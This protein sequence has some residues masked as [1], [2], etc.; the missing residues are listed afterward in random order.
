MTQYFWQTFPASE[1]EKLTAIG[2]DWWYLTDLTRYPNLRVNLNGERFGNETTATLY[3]VHGA[4]LHMQPQETEFII[5]DQS[6]I[7]VVKKKG[8]AGIEEQFGAF[9]GKHEFFMEFNEPNDTKELNEYENTPV[10]LGPILDCFVGE[11]ETVYKAD[12]IEGL[13]RAMGVDE[14]AFRA[15]VD[16]YNGAVE[17][18]RDDLFFA[19]TKRL[20]PVKKGPFYAVRSTARNLGTLGGMYGKAYVD[21]E[22]GTLGF[23]YTSGRLAGEAVAGY[24]KAK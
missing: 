15:S 13:A 19:D 18:G 4:E 3:S 23:A 10:D 1:M 6:M 11:T 14:K 22:G 16:Q 21:F 17:S 7:D 5:L 2:D 12:T 20:V 24:A 8:F 9:K